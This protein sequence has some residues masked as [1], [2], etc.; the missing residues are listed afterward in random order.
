MESKRIEG[1]L[2]EKVRHFP[3]LNE[4]VLNEEEDEFI[5]LEG[6]VSEIRPLS[7]DSANS[8]RFTQKRKRRESIDPVDAALIK[9][10]DDKQTEDS[11]MLYCRSLAEFMRSLPKKKEIEFR[12]EIEKLKLNFIDE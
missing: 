1:E 6:G 3:E 7:N 11:S 12:V 2:I 5:D 4:E 9:A 10:L 8:P